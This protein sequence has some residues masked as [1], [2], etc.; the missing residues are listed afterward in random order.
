MQLISK[1]V[2]T[3][4][5]G[6]FFVEI[7]L[8]RKYL[9]SLPE[10]SQISYHKTK[11]VPVTA[12][13]NFESIK[14]K[15]AIADNG[16]YKLTETE[17]TD[18][19]V[20]IPICAE[21]QARGFEVYMNVPEEKYALK[22]TH[23]LS[24]SIEE[25]YSIACEIPLIVSRRSGILDYLAPSGINICAIYTSKTWH[26]YF[27]LTEWQCEGRVKEIMINSEA[28]SDSLMEEF[29]S[30]LDELKSEGRIS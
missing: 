2:A 13:K 17:E 12:I 28:A 6:K 4:F 27:P 26:N 30:F 3:F 20:Y 10:D 8:L 22:G 14:H 18:R 9:F 24:C 15:I 5:V 29:R 21:L 11:R 19:L 16:C 25:L 7:F 23:A 1:S